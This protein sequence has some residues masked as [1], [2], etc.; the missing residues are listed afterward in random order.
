NRIAT[1]AWVNNFTAGGLPLANGSIWIGNGSNIATPTALGANVATWLGTPSS[2]NLRA[3]LTDETGTG[4][5][6]FQGGDLGTPSAGVLTNATGLPLTTGITGRLPFANLTQGSA[7]SV[8]G[9]TSNSSADN[10]SIQGSAGQIL[11][12]PNA[13][14]SL[15][16]TS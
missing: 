2:A 10:A 9:V 4:A 1:T 13:G 3:A 5:A 14:T 6:Y 16:F 12:V 11:A 8:L 7:R 15:A